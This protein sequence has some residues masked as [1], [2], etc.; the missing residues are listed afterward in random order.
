MK[1]FA[2]ILVALCAGACTPKVG[3]ATD[4]G[5]GGETPDA[6]ADAM[7][8]D[9]D[10]APP[11][12]TEAGPADGACTGTLD[13]VVAMA[14]STSRPACP[15]TYEEAS[16]SPAQCVAGIDGRFQEGACGDALVVVSNCGPYGFVCAYDATSHALAGVAVW[17]DYPRYCGQTWDCIAGGALP[18]GLSCRRDGVVN[19]CNLPTLCSGT[20]TFDTAPEQVHGIC[21]VGATNCTICPQRVDVCGRPIVYT[22]WEM[23]GCA[24]PAPRVDPAPDGGLGCG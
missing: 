3:I 14:Q 8:P 16:A 12:A 13:E 9:A 19:S 7:V 21:P 24:C 2:W 5:D 4:T 6:D 15:A 20:A 17:D 11:D 18:A 1:K 10:V 23:G 22:V